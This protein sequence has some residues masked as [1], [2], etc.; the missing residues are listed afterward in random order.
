MA[1]LEEECGR[2]SLWVGFEVFKTAHVR[3]SGFLFLLPVDLNLELSSALSK[4]VC[5]C[6]AILPTMIIID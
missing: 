6:A 3:P 4:T 1:L 5:L 2:V